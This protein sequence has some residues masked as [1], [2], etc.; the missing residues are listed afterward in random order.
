MRSKHSEPVATLYIMIRCLIAGKG[1][2]SVDFNSL[3]PILNLGHNKKQAIQRIVVVLNMLISI[4]YQFYLIS[5]CSIQKLKRH[6]RYTVKEVP[7]YYLVAVNFIVKLIQY[8]NRSISG[9]RLLTLIN[10]KSSANKQL[11]HLLSV[12]WIYVSILIFQRCSR[13]S[14]GMIM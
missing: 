6:L 12:E 9:A 3:T 14:P 11:Q 13:W 7:N 1:D 5:S 8:L 2:F 4:T 10:Y